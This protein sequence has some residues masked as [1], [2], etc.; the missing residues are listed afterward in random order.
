MCVNGLEHE[1][2][3][4]LQWCTN[5][6]G[7]LLFVYMY[8]WYMCLSIVS[9]HCMFNIT[10]SLSLSPSP[11]SSPF[12]S[13]PSVALL[14]FSCLRE[15]IVYFI[16]THR[17]THSDNHMLSVHA[18][19]QSCEYCLPHCQ[20]GCKLWKCVLISCLCHSRHWIIIASDF[21]TDFKLVNVVNR[22]IDAIIATP[23]LH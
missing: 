7:Y 4:G 6:F 21:S 19:R 13:V 20:Y 18:P 16:Q 22:I 14:C 15:I 2:L 23:I 3:C 11:F 8:L 5:M 1:V 10:F 17:H 9:C 12:R